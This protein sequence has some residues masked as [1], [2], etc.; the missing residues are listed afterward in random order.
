[1]QTIIGLYKPCLNKSDFIEENARMAIM[2]TIM[3]A[4]FA[5][6][7]CTQFDVWKSAYPRVPVY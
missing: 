1:M 6:I 5:H 4:I 3:T 2:C 7:Y